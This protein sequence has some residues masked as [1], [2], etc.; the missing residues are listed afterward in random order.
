[1]QNR[2]LDF[3]KGLA[4]LLVILIH[5]PFPGATGIF[6]ISIARFA[7]PFFFMIS[8]Y[9]L[10]RYCE[11]EKFNQKIKERI[12]RNLRTAGIGLAVYFLIDIVKCVLQSKSVFQFITRIFEIRNL[13]LFVGFNVIPP[14]SGGIVWFVFALIYAYL[15]IL[16]FKPQKK[17]VQT[18]GWAALTWMLVLCAAKVFFTAKPMSLFG[19]DL[20]SYWLYGNWYGI[21]LPSVLLGMMTAQ[22]VDE[23]PEWIRKI[24]K[25]ALPLAVLCVLPN[26]ALCLFLD[27]SLS[28]YLSYTPFTLVM[29]FMVF[30]A[31]TDDRIGQRNLMA[32]IGNR[33]SSDI[34]LW[35]HTQIFI[36]NYVILF[37]GLSGSVLDTWIK[38]FAIILMATA[39]STMLCFIKTKRTI[40][41]QATNA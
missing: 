5:T 18:M 17:H 1:M 30:V 21:G 39:L 40:K 32:V 9:T 24:R 20:S 14:G 28:M 19:L 26:F 3:F 23:R 6:F 4:C 7:V 35:H 16:L 38:P 27:K 22:L 29:D 37:L 31:S 10:Y 34:Y 13:A 8:G 2:T 33:L 25:F 12:L 11:T 36:F 15:A 41:K